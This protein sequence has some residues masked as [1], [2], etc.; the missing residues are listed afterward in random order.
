MSICDAAV[1]AAQT[2]LS[3]PPAVG[4]GKTFW[5]LLSFGAVLLMFTLGL[6]R[7]WL[8]TDV[9]RYLWSNTELAGESFEYDGTAYELLLGFLIALASFCRETP[10]T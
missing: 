7:F 4:C 6:Y 10:G 9:R 8:T 5:R 1:S 3:A 2:R